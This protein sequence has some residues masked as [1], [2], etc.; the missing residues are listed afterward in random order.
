MG[1]AKGAYSLGYIEEYRDPIAA[2]RPEAAESMSETE[3][4]EAA[5]KAYGGSVVDAALDSHRDQA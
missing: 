3:G 5:K 1:Y 2:V 4:K